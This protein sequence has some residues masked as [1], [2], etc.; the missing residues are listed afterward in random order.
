MAWSVHL[1]V[2]ALLEISNLHIANLTPEVSWVWL[3]NSWNSQWINAINEGWLIGW[4]D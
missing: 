1:S 2:L 3:Q 4:M